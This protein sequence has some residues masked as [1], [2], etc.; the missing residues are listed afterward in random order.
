[1][2]N[3]K[4]FFEKY[5]DKRVSLLNKLK[6]KNIFGKRIYNKIKDN[7]ELINYLS[8]NYEKYKNI[9]DETLDS[10]FNDFDIFNLDL[11]VDNLKN[12]DM[13]TD[14]YLYNRM[15]NNMPIS[16]KKIS[17]SFLEKISFLNDLDLSTR[18]LVIKKIESGDKI[19]LEDL[20]TIDYLT[21]KKLPPFLFEEKVYKFLMNSNNSS[22]LQSIFKIYDNKKL[23]LEDVYNLNLSSFDDVELDFSLNKFVNDNSISSQELI[24]LINIFGINTMYNI[25]ISNCIDE[26]CFFALLKDKSIL[27]NKINPNDNLKKFLEHYKN[28]KYIFELYNLFDGNEE[29]FVSF[30]NHT[31]YLYDDLLQE[32]WDFTEKNDKNKE[33]FKYILKLKSMNVDVDVILNNPN[34]KGMFFKVSDEIKD[35]Q[36]NEMCSGLNVPAT[37]RIKIKPLTDYFTTEEIHELLSLSFN[38]LNSKSYNCLNFY[39]DFDYENMFD[40][41]YK[42][43]NDEIVVKNIKDYINQNYV[44]KINLLTNSS[45]NINPDYFLMLFKDYDGLD[46][47][48]FDFFDVDNASFLFNTSNMLLRKWV[49]LCNENNISVN[50]NFIS[51]LNVTDFSKISGSIVRADNFIRKVMDNLNVEITN[52]SV[53]YN[54]M[55]GYLISKDYFYTENIDLLEQEIFKIMNSINDEKYLKNF[56]YLF[57]SVTYKT[58]KTLLSDLSKNIN[59]IS[60][61]EIDFSFVEYII[62]NSNNV[63][64]FNDIKGMINNQYFNVNDNSLP[65][66]KILMENRIDSET[67]NKLQ[68]CYIE[69]LRRKNSLIPYI[70]GNVG[71]YNFETVRIWDNYLMYFD[72]ENKF[73]NCPLQLKEKLMKDNNIRLINVKDS[74]KIINNIV[75]TFN[76]NKLEY[77]VL[78]PINNDI[79]KMNIN[80]VINQINQQLLNKV[81]GNLLYEDPPKVISGDK[82]DKENI[83]YDR[84]LRIHNDAFKLEH[85]YAGNFEDV[86]KT[87]RFSNQTY[88]IGRD[89]YILTNDKDDCLKIEFMARYNQ[90]I[91][92]RVG[93]QELYDNLEKIINS[94]DR[95]INVSAYKTSYYTFCK[96]ASKGSI[97]ILEDRL[98]YEESYGQFSTNVEVNSYKDKND[99]INENFAQGNINIDNFSVL[100]SS[101]GGNAM[102]FFAVKNKKLS[103]KEKLLLEKQKIIYSQI[104]KK[105]EVAR[106]NDKYSNIDYL[107][108][109]DLHNI[110]NLNIRYANFGNKY[111]K[112][113]FDKSKL[114]NVKYDVDF[115]KRINL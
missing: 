43:I 25:V 112:Y 60:D 96:L 7:S 28:S 9:D 24:E 77:R 17:S 59:Y 69:A 81:N 32:I 47:I 14:S 62:R 66:C 56:E 46:K 37:E 79:E 67:F 109:D 30:L 89:W 101:V 111:Q 61:N 57:K 63:N 87:Y 90:D 110:S 12:G 10:L 104:L 99:E 33:R 16:L 98:L 11:L 105:L 100:P 91:D 75:V 31:N 55:I 19:N 48:N 34:Y 58:N 52:S 113:I 2:P 1:M 39:S 64:S 115:N 41:V 88:Y 15:L 70:E 4:V 78:K 40:Y 6:L 35:E 65:S 29:Q 5:G 106:K 72:S 107:S 73:S 51:K 86:K 53:F 54:S 92:N 42:N 74:D 38:Q 114:T 84:L 27:F 68:S 50:V 95:L 82:F 71:N 49:D 8:L 102:K 3:I 103:E 20:K 13:D 21:L 26:K 18:E 85:L 83:E 97:F 45:S 108:K 22:V 80:N 94:T 93:G 44:H 76:D 23:Q 36:I